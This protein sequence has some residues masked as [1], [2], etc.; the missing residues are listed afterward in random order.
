L[1]NWLFAL[2]AVAAKNAQQSV[3]PSSVRWGGASR[4]AGHFVCAFLGLVLSYGSFPFP[5]LFLPSHTPKGHT[6]ANG[7]G[8]GRRPLGGY[9][10]CKNDKRNYYPNRNYLTSY[11]MKNKLTKSLSPFVIFGIALAILAGWIFLQ[12][13]FNGDFLLFVGTLAIFLFFWLIIEAAAR[14]NPNQVTSPLGK[15]L[16]KY[17]NRRDRVV[18]C[19][20]WLAVLLVLF[21][22]S[23][24]PGNPLLITVLSIIVAAIVYYVI[25]LLFG[26][27]ELRESVIPNFIK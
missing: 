5:V 24:L 11:T 12:S 20:A 14:A 8:A 17:P 22:T 2:V 9:S 18:I 25:C 6:P 10:L 26:S 16:S 7:A 21:I 27:R 1:Q 3:H 23:F 15:F 19:I 13:R 4:T